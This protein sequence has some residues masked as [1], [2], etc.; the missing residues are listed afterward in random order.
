MPYN[1]ELDGGPAFPLENPRQLEDG[2]LFKQFPGMSLREYFAGQALVGFLAAHAGPEDIGIPAA[3]HTARRAYEFADA[4][5]A[6][7][8]KAEDR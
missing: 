3:E 8:S 1:C 4:M 6:E 7:R 5:I 2:A